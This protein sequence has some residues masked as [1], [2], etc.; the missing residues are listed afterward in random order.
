MITKVK[1]KKGKLHQCG[2]DDN[3]MDVMMMVIL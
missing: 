2:S 3:L 1:I